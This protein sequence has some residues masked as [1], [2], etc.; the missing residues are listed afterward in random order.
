MVFHLGGAGGSLAIA[1][2]GQGWVAHD[3]I[4]ITLGGYLVVWDDDL[5]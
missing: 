4:E 2:H 1:R 5:T 3:A